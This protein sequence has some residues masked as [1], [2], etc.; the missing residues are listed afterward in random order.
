MAFTQANLGRAYS[1]GPTKQQRV[2][3]AAASGDTSATITFD[4]LTNVGSTLI[5]TLQLLTISYSGNTAV[6]TFTD[7]VATVVGIAEA[8]GT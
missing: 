8:H 1:I 6:I 5:S 4:S 2:S 7:P 3:F